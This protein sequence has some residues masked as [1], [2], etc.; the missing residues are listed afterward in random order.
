MWV[1]ISLD[2]WDGVEDYEDE[3]IF[4]YMDGQPLEVGSVLDDGFVIVQIEG[5]ED[6]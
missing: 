1:D 2:A 3:T 4:F 5:E 6:D